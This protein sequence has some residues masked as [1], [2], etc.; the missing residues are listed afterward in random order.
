M[1]EVSKKITSML[2]IGWL[3]VG[4][5]NLLSNEITK[6]DYFWVWC[7]VIVQLVLDLYE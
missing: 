1:K 3:I 5:I 4:I 2:L 7:V 6:T